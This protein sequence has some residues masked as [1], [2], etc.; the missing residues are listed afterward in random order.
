M[1]LEIAFVALV[2]VFRLERGPVGAD[3]DLDDRSY[4]LPEPSSPSEFL[5]RLFRD[6]GVGLVD[7]R[8]FGPEEFAFR[9]PDAGESER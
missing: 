3:F 4:S 1:D 7:D 6:F 5:A 8:G 9:F 2:A